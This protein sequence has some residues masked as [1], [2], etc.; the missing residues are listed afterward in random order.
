MMERLFGFVPVVALGISLGLGLPP[1]ALAQT[2]GGNFEL[3]LN[4][5]TDV[6]GACRLTFVATNG[7]GV[8]L[9]ATSYE[10]AVF[11]EAG[12]F[13]TIV[14]LEFGEL[15]LNKTRVVQFDIPEQS[16]ANLSRILI[17]GQDQCTSA[18]GDS[19]LCMTALSAS[20]RIPRIPLGL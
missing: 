10:V 13:S 9:T 2:P 6:P 3:E 15:P 4:T 20:S 19:D 14:V 7:T 5:A 12:V 17:N 18:S 11:G 16:C 8:A 1:G